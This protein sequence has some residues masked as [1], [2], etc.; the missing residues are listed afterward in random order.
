MSKPRRILPGTTYLITRRCR[1]RRFLLRPDKETTQAFYYCLSLAASIY[2]IGIAAF[3]ANSNHW[4]GVVVDY[5]GNLVEF[6]HHF[7]L[8]LAKH[9]NC[10]RNRWENMWSSERTSVVELVGAED[11]LDKVGYVLANPVKDHLVA[12]AH[13]WPGASAIWALRGCRTVT[14]TRPHR[15][16]D[17]NGALP[18]RVSLELCKPPAFDGV[19]WS[20]YLAQIEA[21][22]HEREVRAAQERERRGFSV[23]GRSQT[24]RQHWDS[25]PR[26]VA[27]HRTLS[28]RLAC[29]N[30]WARF[31]RMNEDK[32][33]LC[34]YRRARELWLAGDSDVVF[35][36][37][38]YWLRRYAGVLCEGADVS[39]GSAPCGP[40]RGLS[41]PVA[42]GRPPAQP[43]G[44]ERSA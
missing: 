21:V 3:I 10:L 34:A 28:P 29:R 17:R 25:C 24:I 7:H 31:E 32:A 33:W 42:A 11:V 44:R 8:L 14:G 16:F 1:D 6:L 41:T 23:L 30:Q 36:N 20:D 13:S 5:Q 35:P 18:E 19:S 27:T 4:H 26:S 12:S 40:Q 43:N 39:A 2:G 15:F 37:G 38:T 22:V 9:Q